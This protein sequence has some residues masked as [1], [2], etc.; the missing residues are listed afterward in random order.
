MLRISLDS[1]AVVLL[2]GGLDSATVLYVAKA[3]GHHCHTLG[4][5]YGQRHRKELESARRIARHANVSF[6]RVTF[7]LP[8]KGSALLDQTVSLPK[9]RSPQEM[10][11][12]IPVTYVPARNTIFLSFASSFAEA[13][14]APFIYIGANALDFSGY[15][16]CRPDYFERFNRMIEKGTKEREKP[17]E[18]IAP[19]VQKTKAEII[20][21][22]SRLGV[23][24]GWTWSC[25][26]GGAFPCGECDSC[27]LRAKGF[28]EAGVE[29]PLH[30]KSKNQ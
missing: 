21:W 11:R 5:D 2:S 24:Y 28:F 12:E 26:E 30:A 27:L 7:S 23:P 17:I 10:D 15:P 25:Y 18:V 20:Q 1:K 14:G 16:D 19:L 13:I 4:F 29:D 3:E 6:E 22:G 9:G 8:W